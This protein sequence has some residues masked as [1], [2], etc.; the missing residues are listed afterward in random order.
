M[1]AL[2][3]ETCFMIHGDSWMEQ[4]FLKK[5]SRKQT[6]DDVTL[7]ADFFLSRQVTKHG[8]RSSG[9]REGKRTRQVNW[10]TQ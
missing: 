3:I 4:K 7:T 10:N 2:Q 6:K 9:E 8:T 1:N 5:I